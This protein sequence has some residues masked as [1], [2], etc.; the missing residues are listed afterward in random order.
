MILFDIQTGNGIKRKKITDY[1]KKTT[2]DYKTNEILQMVAKK[3][4]F[5]F[6]I[7][8]TSINDSVIYAIFAEGNNNEQK[9]HEYRKT[10]RN[11]DDNNLEYRGLVNVVLSLIVIK[12]GK[13]NRVLL[14]NAF[15][16]INLNLFGDINKVVSKLKKDQW[17]KETKDQNDDNVY[18]E[19]GKKALKLTGKIPIYKSLFKTVKHREPEPENDQ[20]LQRLIKEK[21][22]NKSSNA[23]QRS[24]NRRR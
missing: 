10:I 18:V 7:S 19:F 17:I 2:T 8:L 5:G 3:L 20:L 24:Q 15:D 12:G 22:N 1:L 23:S 9:E 6:G 21:N 13:L 11:L 16:K 14:D 4:H